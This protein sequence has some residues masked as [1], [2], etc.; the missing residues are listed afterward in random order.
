ML[1]KESPKVF[2]TSKS[3]SRCQGIHH[4]LTA[5]MEILHFREFDGR[6]K[7]E[8]LS[9]INDKLKLIKEVKKLDF[10]C[11]SKEATEILDEYLSRD[12]WESVC[13]Q[14]EIVFFHF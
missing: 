3:Y 9:F 2:I 13:Q 8:S 11:F 14:L 7:N 1:E 5:A 6:F 12:T 4:I 10:K